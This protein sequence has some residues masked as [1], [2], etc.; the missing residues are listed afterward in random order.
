MDKLTEEDIKHLKI[1]PAIENAGWS[2]VLMEY[3]FTDGRIFPQQSGS[4][5]RGKRKKADY[6]LKY[7]QECQLAVVEAKDGD[8]SVNAGLLQAIE[9][10]EILNIPFAYSSNGNGFVEHDLITS[11]ECELSMGEFPSPEALRQRYISEKKLTAD[12]LAL[13][14]CPT[15]QEV[16]FSPRYYQKASVDRTLEAITKGQ[17]R[18]LLVLA[19]GTGKTYT[20]FQIAWKLKQLK[21]VRKILYLADRNILISKPFND[22]FSPFENSKYIIKKGEIKTQY[23]IFFGLYQQLDGDKDG[24]S[25]LEVFKQVTPDFF[26]LVI[27]DECH[28]GSAKEDSKWRAVLDYFSNATQIGM[29]ATPKVYG[30]KDEDGQLIEDTAKKYFGDP[31]YSYSLKAGIEDGYLAPF[32]VIQPI[33]NI[34]STGYRPA[35]GELDVYGQPLEDKIYGIRDFDKTLVV[36]KRNFEVA[37]RV[38]DYLKDNGT[39]IKTIIFCCNI[40]HAERIRSYLINLNKDICAKNPRYITRITG[41][42][43]TAD[44]DLNDF[45]K[46]EFNPDLDPCVVTTSDLMT[47][48]VDCKTAKLIVIDK[49][50]NSM[51]LFK[52]IIGRGTRIRLDADKFDFTILDFRKAS[53]LFADPRWDGLIDVSPEIPIGHSGQPVESDEKQYRIGGDFVKVL[54]EEVSILGADGK[55]TKTSLVNYT[56]KNILDEYATLDSFI[57]KWTSAEKHSAIVEELEKRGVFLNE[58]KDTVGIEDMDDFDLICHIAYGLKPLTRSERVKKLRKAMKIDEYTGISKEVIDALLEKYCDDGLDDIDDV[59]VLKLDQF[60]SFGTPK[61]I[62]NDV[63]GGRTNYRDL[64]TLIKTNLYSVAA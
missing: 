41:D 11:T 62:V 44:K 60:K 1:T 31:I 13:I 25:N 27:V 38:N 15:Y 42:S 35:P 4:Y 55:V 7:G 61:H 26:D 58:I 64:V 54:G 52:Q 39:F 53:E 14:E 23:E 17:K 46:V 8:H 51:T 19:T 16:G 47:T 59:A 43:P 50:I 24:D 30:E 3:F 36:D 63:F 9:Y 28:R 48:G 45:T 6:L 29:T 33:L 18:I 5:I 2:A 20:A 32:R 10:A 21:K 22:E 56:K 34:D 40:D 49:V 37:K 12:D 57:Q